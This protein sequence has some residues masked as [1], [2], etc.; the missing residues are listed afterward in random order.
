MPVY[1]ERIVEMV[2][3]NKQTLEVDF[4]QLRKFPVTTIISGSGQPAKAL[5]N[6]MGRDLFESMTLLRTYSCKPVTHPYT[7][8]A[9]AMT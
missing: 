1:Q 8:E 7:W 6:G 2:Q 3:A 9:H 5:A 4:I